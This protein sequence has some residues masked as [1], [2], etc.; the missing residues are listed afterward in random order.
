LVVDVNSVWNELQVISGYILGEG[1]AEKRMEKGA[2]ERVFLP[3][4]TPGSIILP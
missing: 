1:K 2:T 4:V 3:P